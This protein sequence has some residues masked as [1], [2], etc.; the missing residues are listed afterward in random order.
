MIASFNSRGGWVFFLPVGIE[1]S[2]GS[3]LGY[4]ERERGWCI[5]MARWL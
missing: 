2:G 1:I 5:G 3:V 4:L